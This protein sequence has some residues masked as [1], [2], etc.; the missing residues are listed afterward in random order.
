[1]QAF[2]DAG[3]GRGVRT[4]IHPFNPQGLVHGTSS[5]LLSHAHL[6]ARAGSLRRPVASEAAD[7]EGAGVGAWLGG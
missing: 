3:R 7:G 6:L 4:F 5:V 1:M 2:R